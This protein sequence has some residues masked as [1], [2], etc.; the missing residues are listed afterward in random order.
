MI[1]PQET[2]IFDGTIRE[3][4]D[5]MGLKSDKDLWDSLE[6]CQL[7]EKFKT[8]SSLGLDERFL[9]KGLYIFFII[10]KK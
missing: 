2:F 1:I 10:E 8:S 6:K 3:N 4:L 7:A 9:E 5:P